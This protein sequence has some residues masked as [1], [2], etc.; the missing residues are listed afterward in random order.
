MFTI[1]DL[2]RHTSHS[3]SLYFDMTHIRQRDTERDV[4]M[5]PHPKANRSQ[6]QQS[7]LSPKATEAMAAATMVTISTTTANHDS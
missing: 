2:T 3:K 1:L 5:R 7:Q 4:Q 6:K